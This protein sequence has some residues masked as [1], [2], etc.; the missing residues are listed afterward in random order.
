[1]TT[2]S[3]WMGQE[4]LPHE[5]DVRRWI[6]RHAPSQV[7]ED[8]IIQEAYSRLARLHDFGVVRSGRAYFFSTVRNLV[9]EIVRRARIVQI[10]A[11]AEIDSETIVDD[12]P[13]VD[14]SLMGREQLRFVQAAIA[15]LPNRCRHV[16][17]LRRL[18]GLSQKE[19]AAALQ[20]TENI[21]EKEVARALKQ[22]MAKMRDVAT[23]PVGEEAVLDQRTEA[24]RSN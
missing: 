23:Q 6:R 15:E 8:D 4:I 5:R 17:E 19:T 18:Q 13:S 21:V 14:R 10:S 20:L 11:L 22:I 16:F 12:E 3:E 1:M 2:M 24:R 7:D 9:L